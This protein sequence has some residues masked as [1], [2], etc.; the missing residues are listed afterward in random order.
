MMDVRLPNVLILC[1]TLPLLAGCPGRLANPSFDL[2]RDK[3]MADIKRIEHDGLFLRRRVVVLGGWTDPFFVQRYWVDQLVASGV[4]ERDVLGMS[5]VGAFSFDACRQQLLE[6]VE[7]RWPSDDQV[8]TVPVDV[9]AFS[10]GGLVARYAAAPPMVL[11]QA[12]A[13]STAPPR[14]LHIRRLFTISTPH[15][16]ASLAVLPTLDSRVADMRTDSV[17]LSYLD[18]ALR[19]AEYALYPYVRLYDSM[20]G[21][22]NAAPPGMR[23]WWVANPPF[24]RPHHDAYRDP[25]IVADILRRLRGDP[26]WST[27]PP[28]PLPW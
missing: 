14:R 8:L 27:L 2:G 28:A 3:A 13:Q 22:S 1:M 4:D 20:I 21:E 12:Q 5:F 10:M 18:A 9:V 16:G 17:F 7:A 23:A 26:P 19:D 11:P 25:R 15:R 6:A 24:S